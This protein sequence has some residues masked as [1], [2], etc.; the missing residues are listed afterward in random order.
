MKLEKSIIRITQFTL[1]LLLVCLLAGC[2]TSTFTR[3]RLE[4][5]PLNDGGNKQTKNKITFERHDVKTIPPE[6]I[7]TIPECDGRTGEIKLDPISKKPYT[8]KITAL[9]SGSM[10]EKIS[11]TNNT[12][13]VVR[14][15]SAV[16]SAFDPAD[17][18]Y[19]MLSK[20]EI[21]SYLYQQFPCPPSQSGLANQVR[22]YRLIDRNTELLPNRTTTG[23]LVYKPA[24]VTM[25][26][27]WKLAIYDLPVET[28]A[29]GTVVK[30]LNFELKSVAKMYK[31]TYTQEFLKPPVKISTVEVK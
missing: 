16:I 10:L 15:N 5:S 27:V 12:G 29:A 11:I 4:F 20:D 19:Q 31:D 17:N 26:G 28:N 18:Q 3:T 6:F 1:F 14:L 24:D 21:L 22:L 25:P 2:G 13:H 7:A 8:T 30:T 9:P 23:Y